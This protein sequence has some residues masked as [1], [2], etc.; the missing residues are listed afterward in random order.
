MQKDALEN[1]LLFLRT[2]SIT[3]K[4]QIQDYIGM[5]QKLHSYLEPFLLRGIHKVHVRFTQKFRKYVP[6]YGYQ[7]LC[8]CYEVP[9]L[10]YDVKNP[11]FWSK[12]HSVICILEDRLVPLPAHPPLSPG[13]SGPRSRRSRGPR[14]RLLP[15]PR[16]RRHTRQTG[17]GWSSGSKNPRGSPSC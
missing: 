9:N 16:S 14:A 12:C 10:A 6:E 13:A 1:L 11:K 8:P 2:T 3:R 17:A 5:W 15:D 4:M 7:S